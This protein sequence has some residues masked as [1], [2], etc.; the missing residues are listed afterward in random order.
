MHQSGVQVFFAAYS[1]NVDGTPAYKAQTAPEFLDDGVKNTLT[2]VALIVTTTGLITL[3]ILRHEQPIRSQN[4]YLWVLSLLAPMLLV[5]FVY[6]QTEQD[7]CFKTQ[8]VAITSLATDK[9][10]VIGQ[11]C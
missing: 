7:R 8:V 5:R 10:A 4:I 11:V 9:I 6:N 1:H 3:Y 2:I